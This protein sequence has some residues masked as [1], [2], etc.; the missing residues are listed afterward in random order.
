MDLKLDLKLDLDLDFISPRHALLLRELEAR[1]AGL[2]SGFEGKFVGFRAWRKKSPDWFVK[3]LC[4]QA[5]L[6]K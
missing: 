3:R 4:K 2:H 5:E 6:D 1:R